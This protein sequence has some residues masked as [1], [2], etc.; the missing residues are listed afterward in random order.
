MKGQHFVYRHLVANAHLQRPI[1]AKQEGSA[2][3]QSSAGLAVASSSSRTPDIPPYESRN[4]SQT[5]AAPTIIDP[6]VSC[7]A[8]LVDIFNTYFHTY[9]RSIL[10]TA[11]CTVIGVSPVYVSL[12]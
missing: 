6:R 12:G 1:I 5:A 11:V 9:L 7:Y 3:G 2:I 4:T 10:F 8:L